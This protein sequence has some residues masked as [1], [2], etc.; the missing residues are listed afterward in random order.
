MALLTPQVDCPNVSSTN[1]RCHISTVWPCLL[2]IDRMWVP[3]KFTSPRMWHWDSQTQV[4]CSW[5]SELVRGGRPGLGTP[6]FCQCWWKQ[7]KLVCREGE[8][9]ASLW[10]WEKAAPSPGG[11]WERKRG[12]LVAD[13]FPVLKSSSCKLSLS[14][15][16]APGMLHSAPFPP[17]SSSE[18]VYA[19]YNPPNL[20][21]SLPLG[22]KK[23][24]R[25]VW[26]QWK[27]R[28]QVLLQWERWQ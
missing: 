24:K 7:R 28:L 11:D 23:K 9:V 3:I 21:L 19:S 13:S 14:C 25:E 6:K 22:K 8:H 20:C 12:W 26:E 16:W 27:L 10:S 2:I 15:P 17:L 18:W 4:S 5:V 1:P